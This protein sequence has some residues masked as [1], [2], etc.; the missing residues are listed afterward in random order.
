MTAPQTATQQCRAAACIKISVS[1]GRSNLAG[2]NWTVQP[3]GGTN[4]AA[5]TSWNAA[6]D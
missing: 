1:C 6:Q 5:H 4:R 2:L 3:I